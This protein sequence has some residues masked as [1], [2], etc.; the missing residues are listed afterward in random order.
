MIRLSM[1]QRSR[2]MAG[3]NQIQT[4]KFFAVIAMLKINANAG[5][6]NIA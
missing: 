6:N 1:V 5:S 2:P 4:L 3:K